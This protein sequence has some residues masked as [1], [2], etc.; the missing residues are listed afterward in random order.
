MYITYWVHLHLLVYVQ[1]W[2][3]GI[4]QPVWELLLRG[5]WFLLSHLALWGL[6]EFPLSNCHVNWCCH[7]AGL[8]Q[9]TILFRVHGYSVPVIYRRHYLTTTILDFWPYHSSPVYDFPWA[10]GAGFIAD[11][12]IGI[13]HTKVI[14]L[15]IL[16]SRDLALLAIWC[17]RYDRPLFWVEI[18]LEWH[19]N[20]RKI[21]VVFRTPFSYS[22]SRMTS[23]AFGRISLWTCSS[24]MTIKLLYVV[25]GFK[26][27]KVSFT[28]IQDEF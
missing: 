9:A 11:V 21:T 3:L 7:Y 13:G 26:L 23:L 1:G 25:V 22:Q 27:K 2:P 19:W 8:V 24:M 5:Y 17:P 6:L 4:G 15:C 10:L 20:W 16:I 14:F 12:S 28:N 18:F